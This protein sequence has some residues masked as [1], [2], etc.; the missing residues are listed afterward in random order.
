VIVGDATQRQTLIGDKNY[1][2]R[3]FEHQLAEH[4]IRLMRA[5][6]KGEPERPGAE[7]FKP[8]RQV[9]ESVNETF[10]GQL[11][12]ERHHGRTPVASSPASCSASSR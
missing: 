9:I 7:L 11:D 5:T 2:G 1:F 12:L 4:G 8:L 3:D 6:R 10:K